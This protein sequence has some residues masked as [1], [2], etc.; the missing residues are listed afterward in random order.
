MIHAIVLAAG[1]STRMGDE[2]K[3]L[4]QVNGKPM[5]CNTVEHVC[6]SKASHVTV[7]V[8]HQSDELIQ[9]MEPYDVDIMV[10][11]SYKKGMTTSIQAGL[12]YLR[13]HDQAFMI[14]LGDMPMLES[15]HIDL[16]IDRFFENQSLEKRLIVR[17]VYRG[18][19]GHPVI[20][21]K[22]Y[23]KD[24][25]NLLAEQPCQKVINEHS[26]NLL[27]VITS[28]IHFFFDVDRPIDKDRMERFLTS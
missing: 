5:I 1:L 19:V 22:S 24:I 8:G 6:D 21:D 15:R 12:S 13:P 9:V 16:L 25:A 27:E 28:D 26:H 20:F 10:N 3:M 2:N 11:G 14:C 18:N 7:V 4:V 17:P 23:A